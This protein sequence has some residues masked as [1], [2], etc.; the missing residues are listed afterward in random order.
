MSRDD[1]ISVH[2]VDSGLAGLVLLL[3][4]HGIAATSD[5]IRHQFVEPGHPIDP[6]SMLRCAKSFG[7]KA[8]TVMA[9]AE[10]LSNTPLPAIAALR[11]GG[12]LVLARAAEGKI[13]VQDPTTGETR[14]EDS[15]SLSQIWTGQL[16]L[17]ARRA[18]LANLTEQFGLSWFVGAVHKYRHILSEVLIA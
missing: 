1:T 14:I 5:Q 10:R 11:S 13:L 9:K 8:R 6:M 7:L 2:P 17:L 12:W 4:F 16:I 15:A 3:R 18:T